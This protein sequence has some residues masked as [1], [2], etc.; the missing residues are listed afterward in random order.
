[1]PLPFLYSQKPHKF[2]YSTCSDVATSFVFKIRKELQV[3]RKNVFFS[4]HSWRLDIVRGVE[5]LQQVQDIIDGNS[6]KSMRT[7]A[8]Q[9]FVS[10]SR[11]R[12]VVHK[13]IRWE[14]Y[15]MRKGQL[16]STRTR[17]DSLIRSK[18][19]QKQSQELSRLYHA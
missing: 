6:F 5:L 9:F 17:E 13:D 3:S 11:I 4:G 12:R 15:D 1:M 18:R 2:R 8:S 7:V 16:M 10:E 19:L 14:F